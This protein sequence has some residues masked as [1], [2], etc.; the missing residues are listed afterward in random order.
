MAKDSQPIPDVAAYVDS[1]V[2]LLGYDLTP[3]MRQGVIDNLERIAA[4][5]QTVNAFS[6]PVDIE[7]APTFDP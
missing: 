7:A 4:I 3:A 1:M 6:L 2:P 5:A